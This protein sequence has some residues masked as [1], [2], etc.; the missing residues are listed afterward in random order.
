MLCVKRLQHMEDLCSKL[1]DSEQAR[2]TLEKSRTAF[3]EVQD[4]IEST[5]QKLMQHPDKWKE[6][7]TR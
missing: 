5:H 2:Q 1:T 3:A 7:N 6:F 4:E